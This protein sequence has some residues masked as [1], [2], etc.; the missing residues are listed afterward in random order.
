M[1]SWLGVIKLKLLNLNIDGEQISVKAEKL[2]GKTWI[3]YNDEV[4]SFS[5]QKS[6]SKSSGQKTQ[7]VT[8]ILAPMP[9][10]ILKVNTNSSGEYKKGQT[11]IV[12][13]AMKME[14]SLKVMADV[15]L[16]ALNCNTGDQVSQ[17]QVLANFDLI[18]PIED[19]S[20][21]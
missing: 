16:K 7:D 14:Y 8:K 12:M 3:H 6:K 17:D 19:K 11:V 15:K 13:E 21:D 4:I 20:E 2:N 10:T 18:N 1:E 5:P 9:G